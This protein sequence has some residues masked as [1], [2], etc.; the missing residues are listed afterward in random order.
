MFAFNLCHPFNNKIKTYRMNITHHNTTQKICFILFFI[1]LITGQVYDILAEKGGE[2]KEKINKDFIEQYKFE[3]AVCCILFKYDNIEI[4]RQD[5]FILSYINFLNKSLEN[6]LSLCLINQK[7][8]LV[9]HDRMQTIREYILRNHKSQH[10]LV[11]DF[12]IINN[13]EQINCETYKDLIKVKLENWNYKYKLFIYDYE[14]IKNSGYLMHYTFRTESEHFN[15]YSGSCFYLVLRNGFDSEHFLAEFRPMIKRCYP[16]NVNLV[17]GY[18]LQLKYNTCYER[19]EV[20]VKQFT[21]KRLDRNY[22]EKTIDFDICKDDIK[23]R[24]HRNTRIVPPTY[25]LFEYFFDFNLFTSKLDSTDFYFGCFCKKTNGK[26]D[27]KELITFN[28]L[29]K[30]KIVSPHYSTKYILFVK[31]GK[32]ILYNGDSY[33]K[34]IAFE[35]EDCENGSEYICCLNYS[36][37]KKDD[38]KNKYLLK[39]SKDFDR[40]IDLL[41]SNILKCTQNCFFTNTGYL[42]KNKN[43]LTNEI[44]LSKGNKDKYITRLSFLEISNLIHSIGYLKSIIKSRIL[45]V[46]AFY[47]KIKPKYQNFKEFYQNLDDSMN[48]YCSDIAITTNFKKS[49]LQSKKLAWKIIT[50]EGNQ[51]VKYYLFIIPEIIFEFKKEL[52]DDKSS[53]IKKILNTIKFESEVLSKG[54]K[55]DLLMSVADSKF[56]KIIEDNLVN[57]FFMTHETDQKTYINYLIDQFWMELFTSNL[58]DEELNYKTNEFQDF[59]EILCKLIYEEFKEVIEKIKCNKE[60][61]NTIIYLESDRSCYFEHDTDVLK[62]IKEVYPEICDK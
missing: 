35:N 46:R 25:E 21:D 15:I 59:N 27:I 23:E 42:L 39:K 11:D 62:A 1:N 49:N 34:I 37:T 58:F 44:Y 2:L 50:K 48:S 12:F 26:Y 14:L 55:Q 38:V 33:Q 61:F 4:E 17:N 53:Y 41:Y 9:E 56:F 10:D 18:H 36:L 47:Y 29:Y 20:T 7:M 31:C 24:Y 28:I 45:N 3:E 32:Q 5:D 19:I 43:W 54:I 40:M 16:R 8:N 6:K 22:V 60:T 30:N 13:I 52:L 57:C 51:E